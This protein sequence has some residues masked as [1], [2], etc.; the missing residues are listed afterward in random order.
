M[1]FPIDTKVKDKLTNQEWR[2]LQYTMQGYQSSEV[3]E[4]LGISQRTVHAHENNMRAKFGS[5]NMKSMVA[6]ACIGE[7]AFH[8]EPLT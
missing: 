1:A 4:L 2:V 3:A 7:E 5:V 8:N 6:I